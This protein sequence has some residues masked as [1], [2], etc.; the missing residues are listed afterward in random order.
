L[1]EERL[2]ST[3]QRAGNHPEASSSST[4]PSDV[5]DNVLHI[6]LDTGIHSRYTLIKV[7]PENV[8]P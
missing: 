1:I 3:A 4:N 8:L 6:Y 2:T 7:C 5:H